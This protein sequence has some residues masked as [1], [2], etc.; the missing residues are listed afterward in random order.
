M[1][2]KRFGKYGLTI[3]PDK[4]RLVPF[5]KPQGERKGPGLGR[6]GNV[7]L[8]GIHAPFGAIPEGELGSEAE[9]GR[10]PVHAGGQDDRPMVPVSIATTRLRSNTRYSARNSKGTR[11]TTGSRATAQSSLPVS[12]TRC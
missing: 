5:R 2:P 3:H 10:Q 4:T 11:G 1:L 8:P 9:D 7:R 6:A 12:T